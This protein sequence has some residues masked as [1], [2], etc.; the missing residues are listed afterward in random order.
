MDGIL[1]YVS[2]TLIYKI[3]FTISHIMYH[4]FT[5]KTLEEIVFEME[6]KFS[7]GEL[8]IEAFAKLRKYLMSIL[9]KNDN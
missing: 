7:R 4:Q 3:S 1:F 8:T 9:E 6:I 5:D 2:Y